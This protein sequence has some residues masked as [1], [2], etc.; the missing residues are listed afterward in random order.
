MS[1]TFRL[2]AIARERLTE[3]L[4]RLTP[5]ELYYIGGPD[6]LPAPLTLEE[7]QS[8]CARLHQDDGTIRIPEVLRPYMGGMERIEK[9]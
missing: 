8:L 5:R 2:Y 6:P 1:I 7:E 3:L 4:A 9:N